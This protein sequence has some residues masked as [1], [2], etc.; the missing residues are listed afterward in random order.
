MRNFIR[1]IY[2]G[3][4]IAIK[5]KYKYLLVLF[6][7]WLFRVEFIPDL[8]SGEA[9]KALQVGCLFGMLYMILKWKSSIIFFS[10][11]KTNMAIKSVLWLYVFALFSTLWAFNPQ[12]AFFLS[13]Q[14]L[15]LIITL[16]FIYSR[17]QTFKNA[18]RM[19]VLFVS[20]MIIFESIS[21]RFTQRVLIAHFLPAASSAAILFS[22][23]IAEYINTS[24]YEKARK[25]ILKYSIVLSII[26]LLTCT[27]GGANASAAFGLSVA[28]FFSKKRFYAVLMFAAAAFLFFNRDLINELIMFLMPGK[29]M[30][31][32]ESGNGRETIWNLLFQ[33]AAE[34]PWF[35]WGFACI[36]RVMSE[37]AIKGQILSDAHNSY[38]GIYGSLGIVGCIFLSIHILNQ[39]FAIYPRIGKPGYAGL[40]AA[41]CCALLNSYT[42]GFLSG[43]ACSI[44]V[45]YFS[46]VVLTFYYKKLK[47]NK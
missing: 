47:I 38:I 16:V 7:L 17:F 11:N 44:T 43:K 19:F 21:I 10:F 22:Y 24:S 15:V 31:V 41:T 32:I 42:Y 34:R 30:E 33:I 28:L 5:S 25:K 23:S 8:G 46:L 37:E 1:F 3:L 18:E 12:F 27:S 6:A 4:H 36:E 29:T 35:G 9:A 26:I 14:N 39:L 45:T 2:Q 40:F 20:I 13:F